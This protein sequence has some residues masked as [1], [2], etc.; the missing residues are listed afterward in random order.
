MQEKKKQPIMPPKIDAKEVVHE[1]EKKGVDLGQVILHQLFSKD[2][3]LSPKGISKG[4]MIA[5]IAVVAVFALVIIIG[6]ISVNVTV[7]AMHDTYIQEKEKVIRAIS[8]IDLANQWERLPVQD[9]KE[10]LRTQF[11]KIV[12]YYTNSTPDDKKMNNTQT[13][14]TFNQLWLCTE[15]VPSINFFLA[16]AY[17]KV[18]T[19]FNPVYNSSYRY[20]LSGMYLK[21]L[22]SI[23]N[24]P[25]VRND[26]IFRTT[27]SGKKT[28]HNPVESVKLLIAKIED[29]ARTFNNR[30]DWILLSLFSNEYDVIS[31]YWDNGK[32]TIPDDKYK[33]GDLAE[34]LKYYY[35]FKN[36]QIP[37][38]TAQ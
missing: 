36:W 31:K 11:T 12:M 10:R 26:P 38:T 34:A 25:L 21:E 37:A 35:A 29:L 16:V 4:W 1:L 17:M 8:D 28:A 13:L 7:N 30:E 15:R 22:E 19:N 23:A 18:R 14:D 20:G 27:Y 5:F 32:G 33:K 24:L 2:T 3:S 9:R 6:S